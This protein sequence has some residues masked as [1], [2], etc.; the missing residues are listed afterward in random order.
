ME[1]I[2]G[3]SGL[4]VKSLLAMQWPPVRFRTIAGT[5]SFCLLFPLTTIKS[6][7]SNNNNNNRKRIKFETLKWEGQRTIFS[8]SPK[9]YKNHQ[10]TVGRGEEEQNLK[11]HL[12]GLKEREHQKHASTNESENLENSTQNCTG[13]ES[14][15]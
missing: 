4:V 5:E 1:L 9:I 8:Q 12:S 14:F 2:V 13:H 15:G 10:K 3:D 6:I 7:P 11:G